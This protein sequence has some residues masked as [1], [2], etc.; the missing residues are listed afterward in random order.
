VVRLLGADCPGVAVLDT[1]AVLRS[2]KSWGRALRP[3]AAHAKSSA[4][5]CGCR[6][7]KQLITGHRLEV[8]GRDVIPGA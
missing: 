5:T 6:L 7:V 3:P 4:W 1:R 8:R 2:V